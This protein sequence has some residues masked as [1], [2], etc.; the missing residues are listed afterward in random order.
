LC[1]RSG[2]KAE[3]ELIMQ[4]YEWIQTVVPPTRRRLPSDSFSNQGSFPFV[5]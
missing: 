1:K 3:L 2:R 5:K 4:N